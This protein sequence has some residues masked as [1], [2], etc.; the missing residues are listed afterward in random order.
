LVLNTVKPHEK[1]ILYFVLNF[2]YIIREWNI[3]V[4]K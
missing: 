3:L 1:C 4:W 2:I